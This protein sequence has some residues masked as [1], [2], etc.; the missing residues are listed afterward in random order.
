[1][2]SIDNAQNA[3]E[4]QQKHVDINTMNVGRKERE[5]ERGDASK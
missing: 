2:R 5:R 3:Q 1:M 4:G